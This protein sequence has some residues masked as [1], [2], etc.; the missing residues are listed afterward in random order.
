[1]CI[2]ICMKKLGS[3]HKKFIEAITHTSG[4]AGEVEGGGEGG[5]EPCTF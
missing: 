1:M 3:V 5:L 4:S 2:C